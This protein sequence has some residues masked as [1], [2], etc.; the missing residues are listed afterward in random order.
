MHLTPYLTP[1]DQLWIVVLGDFIQFILI[2]I[3]YPRRSTV[4]LY[5][6][7]ALKRFLLLKESTIFLFVR[8]QRETQPR[9]E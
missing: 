6:E 2:I 8:I 5:I 3:F 1:R 9:R 4:G 7:D